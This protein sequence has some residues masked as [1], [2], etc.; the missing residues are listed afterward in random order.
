MTEKEKPE[1]LEDDSDNDSDESDE[2]LR[3]L[4]KYMRVVEYGEE[5]DDNIYVSPELEK[6][7]FKNK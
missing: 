2:D 4:K 6:Y 5:Y 1:F 3:E 7:I